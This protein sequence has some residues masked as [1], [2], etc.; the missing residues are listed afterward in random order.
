M[1]KR[2]LM[3]QSQSAFERYDKMLNENPY[4]LLNVPLQ[5]T[6]SF[7]GINPQHRSRLRRELLNWFLNIYSAFYLFKTHHFNW[8]HT[9]CWHF[10][11]TIFS[12]N[13][14]ARI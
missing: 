1:E 11:K 14:T 2:I 8:R 6:A 7:L 5:Y 4:I 13:Y 3:L 9:C 10:Y 12:T